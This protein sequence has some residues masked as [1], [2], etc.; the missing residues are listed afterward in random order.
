MERKRKK[1]VALLEEGGEGR[2]LNV[3][4]GVERVMTVD[5][6]NLGLGYVVE[7]LNHLF[8]NPG[9]NLWLSY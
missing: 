8:F 5:N 6:K 4:D 2:V 7:L 9:S 1:K 3:D